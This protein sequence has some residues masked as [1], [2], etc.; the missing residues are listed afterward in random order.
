M[1]VE[2]QRLDKAVAAIVIPQDAAD[3][4]YARVL[5]QLQALRPQRQTAI[6]HTQRLLNQV[7]DY[8]AGM[9]A[10]LQKRS[11]EHQKQLEGHL[12]D[13]QNLTSRLDD[14]ATKCTNARWEA[15]A[16]REIVRRN[17]EREK[18]VIAAEQT[19]RSEQTV[20]QQQVLTSIPANQSQQW[21]SE[22]EQLAQQWET[23]CR[24]TFKS[25]ENY[26]DTGLQ[27][28]FTL[29]NRTAQMDAKGFRSRIN[30]VLEGWSAMCAKAFVCRQ[31]CKYLQVERSYRERQEAFW[32]NV[33]ELAAL[34]REIKSCQSKLQAKRQEVTGWSYAEAR[35]HRAEVQA[36]WNREVAAPRKT[37]VQ[38]ARVLVAYFSAQ[39]PQD[40]W[41]PTLP[42]DRQLG[43]KILAVPEVT[44]LEAEH[45]SKIK[46][47]V[48]E[49][50]TKLANLNLG[51]RK[52]TLEALTNRLE[53]LQGMAEN[54][55]YLDTEDR[56]NKLLNL[57]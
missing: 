28:T 20:F 42:Y 13:F 21:Y 26:R 17:A 40:S 19:L 18:Y 57:K 14:L 6:E 54:L 9:D 12:A 46:T 11:R 33:E 35:T 22:L 56:L 5:D 10:K 29:E 7:K 1:V 3:D 30:A 23:K 45:Q 4:E 24:E 41:D 8:Q 36:W 25:L 16:R 44:Q 55:T 48:E 37:I 27:D 43:T 38:R 49:Q 31:Q 51:N 34:E 52:A 39:L 15:K 2:A 50:A 53:T 47:L 32:K